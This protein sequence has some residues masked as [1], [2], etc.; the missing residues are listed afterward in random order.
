[1]AALLKL[2]QPPPSHCIL[3]PAIVVRHALCL[4]PVIPSEQIESRGVAV[5][6]F[7]DIKA[8]RP[9]GTKPRGQF[10][11]RDVTTLRSNIAEDLC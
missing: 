2:L 11:L 8:N 9:S 4:P 3:T 10:D 6:Y 5:T 1:M 7:A